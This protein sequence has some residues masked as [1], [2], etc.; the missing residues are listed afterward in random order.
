[1]MMS[2]FPEEEVL[3]EKDNRKLW[4]PVVNHVVE[5]L[6]KEDKDTGIEMYQSTKE[7][8]LEYV[9]ADCGWVRSTNRRAELDVWLV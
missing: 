9:E 5:S 7:L 6:S 3:K 2:T 4:N 8:S 1:M